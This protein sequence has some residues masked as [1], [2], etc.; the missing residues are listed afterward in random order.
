MLVALFV[1]AVAIELAIKGLS[2]FCRAKGLIR[3]KLLP[4]RPRLLFIPWPVVNAARFCNCRNCSGLRELAGNWL[5]KVRSFIL[6]PSGDVDSEFAKTFKAA[7]G[8]CGPLSLSPSLVILCWLG[9]CVCV[10]G[11]RDLS[12]DLWSWV[13]LFQ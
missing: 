3:F 12:L 2:R 6:E 11:Y 8:N 10:G 9:A 7:N 5:S 13:C 4:K 1:A